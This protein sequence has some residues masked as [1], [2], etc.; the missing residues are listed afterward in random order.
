MKKKN[1]N[2]RA[3]KCYVYLSTNGDED[4]SYIKE[5]KQLKVIAQYA[6]AHNLEISKIM[7]KGI[8]G[9]FEMNKQFTKILSSIQKKEV[10]ALL[11]AK[12]EC[13]SNYLPDIYKAVALVEAYG[14]EFIT[15]SKGRL[16]L[17]LD[18][19]GGKNER[20]K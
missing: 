16:S 9:R 3:K 2:I 18:S 12:P 5:N 11:V 10:E 7:R 15:A 19:K 20:V 14:G 1:Q 13:I 6:K 17:Y 4:T 8:L